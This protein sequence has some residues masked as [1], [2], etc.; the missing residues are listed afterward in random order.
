MGES[1]K[2]YCGGAASTLGS[3]RR[4]WGTNRRISSAS[5][6]R[7][8]SVSRRKASGSPQPSTMSV[9]VASS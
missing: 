8:A 4:L 9:A 7:P 3:P 6:L 2:R 1:V 5:P